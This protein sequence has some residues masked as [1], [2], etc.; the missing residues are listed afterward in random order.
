MDSLGHQE[1]VSSGEIVHLDSYGLREIIFESIHDEI[2][3]QI[4]CSKRSMLILS[5][6]G[7]LYSLPFTTKCSEVGISSYASA[8]V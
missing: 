6:G 8:F 5:N 4:A 7:L 2:I 3:S 1:I